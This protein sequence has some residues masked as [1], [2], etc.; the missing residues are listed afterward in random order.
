MVRTELVPAELL[1]E[2]P[3]GFTY[4]CPLTTTVYMPLYTIGLPADTTCSVD[5]NNLAQ[6]NKP[7][8]R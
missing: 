7:G 5:H 6:R 8:P 2:A 4:I 3:A 1:V